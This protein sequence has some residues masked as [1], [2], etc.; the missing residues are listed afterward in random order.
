MSFEIWIFRNGQPDC[1]D[2]RIIVVAIGSSTL[3]ITVQHKSPRITYEWMS[4]CCLMPTHNCSAISWWEQVNFQWDN[5]GEVSFVLDQH[6]ELDFYSASSLK[7]QFTGRH[8]APHSDKLFWFRVNQSLLLL[9]NAECFAE[10][11]QIT[12]V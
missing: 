6:A 4:E 3:K 5:D 10:K 1:D 8:V 9:L 12:I 7:Q 11:Q 2:D